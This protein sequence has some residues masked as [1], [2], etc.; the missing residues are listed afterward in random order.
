MKWR[1]FISN[2][3]HETV[4]F[5]NYPQMGWSTRDSLEGFYHGAT[6]ES[7]ILRTYLLNLHF[8]LKT[9]DAERQPAV[10]GGWLSRLRRGKG[11][12]GM[13]IKLCHLAQ[14]FPSWLEPETMKP[15]VQN[16][17]LPSCPLQ[18]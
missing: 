10:V 4:I 18:E 7:K 17:A 1:D 8:L 6:A 2:L 15:V 5:L 11:K 13:P 3:K 14:S 16:P 9:P 12:K